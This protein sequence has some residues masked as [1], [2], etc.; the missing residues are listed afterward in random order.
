MALSA[1]PVE[2]PRRFGDALTDA[3]RRVAGERGWEYDAWYHDAPVWIV[4]ER[5][6]WGAHGSVVCRVQIAVFDAEHGPVVEAIP[7]AY[8]VAGGRVK[9]KARQQDRR[10]GI[11]TIPAPPPE[12]AHDAI[13]EIVLTAWQSASALADDLSAE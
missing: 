12:A 10:A 3:V 2:V 13:A 7:D 4:R 6:P 11:Q 1:H 8:A 5:R 9:R